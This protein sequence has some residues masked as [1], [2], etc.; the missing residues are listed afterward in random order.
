MKDELILFLVTL[1]DT[2][3]VTSAINRYV[4]ASNA[5]RTLG[6][7]PDEYTITPLTFRGDTV[8]L[9]IDIKF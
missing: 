7:Y 9:D 2:H 4:A 1:D 3:V 6:G 5:Y 8:V